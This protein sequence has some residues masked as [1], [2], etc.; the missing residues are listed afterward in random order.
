MTYWELIAAAFHAS[1]QAHVSLGLVLGLECVGK[2]L[3]QFCAM[4][5]LVA[6]S[7][8]CGQDKDHKNIFFM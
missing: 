5:V 2:S 3:V 8:W 1:L 6:V 4:K 7:S